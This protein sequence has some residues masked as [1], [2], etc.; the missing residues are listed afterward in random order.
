M[1]EKRMSSIDGG[2]C[3]IANLKARI[4]QLDKELKKAYE[5]LGYGA[6]SKEGGVRSDCSRDTLNHL[7]TSH[8]VQSQGKTKEYLETSHQGCVRPVAA[9]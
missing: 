8:R 2:D 4:G 5:A 6:K 3:T 7:D 1:M 9:I